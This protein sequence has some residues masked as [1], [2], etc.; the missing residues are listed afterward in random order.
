MDLHGCFIGIVEK[1]DDPEKLGRVKVRVPHVY[2]VF[3]LETGAVALDDIPWALPVGLPAGGSNASGGA[4]WLPEPGDQVMVQFL[5]GEPEKPIWSWLMQT[6]SQAQTLKLHKYKTSDGKVGKPERAAWTR[7]GHTVEWNQAS[8]IVTT[9]G[10][11]RLT[12]IDGT[13]DGQAKLSSAKGQFLSFDDDVD[14]GTLNITTDFYMQIGEQLKITCENLSFESTTGSMEMT[15]GDEVKLTALSDIVIKTEGGLSVTTATD[16]AIDTATNLSLNAEAD[17]SLAFANLKLGASA[18]EPF[19]LG[20]QLTTFLNTLMLWL[21]THTHTTATEGS[22][23]SPPIVPP[24]TVVQPNVT[25]LTSKVI[26][27]Q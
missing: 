5:D 27:G 19:V 13:D 17:M 10:G 21:A 22:P 6:R 1:I 25:L 18:T 2:G 7:Y 23:T 16:I 11:Y 4:S 9:A 26:T 14:T 3:G 12:L 8:L 20:T 24:D 15:C